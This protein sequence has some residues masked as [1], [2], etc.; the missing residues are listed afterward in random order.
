MSPPVGSRTGK[1]PEQS[2]P[3]PTSESDRKYPKLPPEDKEEVFKGLVTN[4]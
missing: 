4:W 3:K 1:M 2:K